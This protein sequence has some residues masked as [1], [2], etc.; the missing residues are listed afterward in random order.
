M[1]SAMEI[2][3]NGGAEQLARMLP[4]APDKQSAGLIATGTMVQRKAYKH[5]ASD[6][7]EVFPA[8]MPKGRQQR[9]VDVGKPA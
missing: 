6:G 8:C 2:V 7:L 1:D 4:R 3:E 9:D 5:R